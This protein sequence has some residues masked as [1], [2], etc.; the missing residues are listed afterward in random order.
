M[1]NAC[2]QY[3]YTNTSNILNNNDRFFSGPN[4]Q[5]Q[6]APHPA[7]QSR[8]TCADM[9]VWV[10]KGPG[11]VWSRAGGY[12]YNCIYPWRLWCKRGGWVT[13]YVGPCWIWVSDIGVDKKR[14]DR[15]GGLGWEALPPS[16]R[17]SPESRRRPPP[18]PPPRRQS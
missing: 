13:T 6:H 2:V 11:Y 5:L 15:D 8:S 10:S 9:W 17:A 7:T 14:K 4:L 16:R 1:K 18:K 3:R 12:R